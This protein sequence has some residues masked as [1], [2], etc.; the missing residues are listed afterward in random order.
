[1]FLVAIVVVVVVVTI[2]IVALAAVNIQED[3][4]MFLDNLAMAHF[5][6]IKKSTRSFCDKHL[7]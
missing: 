1:M 5:F 6:M 2:A 3:T 7:L 4:M